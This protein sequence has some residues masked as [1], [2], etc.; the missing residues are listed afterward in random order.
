MMRSGSRPSSTLLALENCFV[1]FGH[2]LRRAYGG[3]GSGAIESKKEQ[4]AADKNFQL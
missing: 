3:N 1:R 2:D 4:Y